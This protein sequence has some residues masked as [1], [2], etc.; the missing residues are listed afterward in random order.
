MERRARGSTGR[1]LN[2]RR[3]VDLARHGITANAILPGWVET[4][5]LE[6]LKSWDKWEKMSAGVVA[7]TPLRR[8]GSPEDFEAIAVY[9]ASDGSRFHTGDMI[10]IDGGFVC[11]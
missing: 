6:P 1:A 5:I 9:L 7:R 4:P 2:A 3:R 10:S 11:A 8:W